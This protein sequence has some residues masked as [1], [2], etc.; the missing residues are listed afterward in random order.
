M[1]TGLFIQTFPTAGLR[2]KLQR[3]AP[4][5]RHSSQINTQLSNKFNKRYA[6]T[7]KTWK[8]RRKHQRRTCCSIVESVAIDGP[9]RD[10]LA[11][12]VSILG[13]RLVVRIFDALET[14]GTL[15]KA[16]G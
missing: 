13:S 4:R 1:K 3:P 2:C 15:D 8:P 14:S 10:V 12:S 16:S 5:W 6:E 11:F 7:S 9:V